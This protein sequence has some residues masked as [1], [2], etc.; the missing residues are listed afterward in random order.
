MHN[1]VSVKIRVDGSSQIGLGHLIRCIALGQM[2]RDTFSIYFYSKEIP[3]SIISQVRQEGFTFKKL[4]SED[5]FLSQ[6]GADEIV[7][8]D[9]YFF[10]TDYQRRIKSLGCKLVCIDDIHDKKFVSDIII[11]P[12]EGILDGVYNISQQITKL[13]CGFRYALIRDAVLASSG[14]KKTQPSNKSLFICLGGADPNNVTMDI[15][16]RILNHQPSQFIINIVVGSAY[17]YYNNLEKYIT[18]CHNSDVSLHSNISV[19]SMVDLMQK[20]SYAICS[21]STIAIEYLSVCRGNLFLKKTADNQQ[22]FYS[23]V[24]KSNLAHTLDDFFSQNCTESN[25]SLQ[26]MLFDGQQGLRI[27]NIF[28][29]LK[30]DCN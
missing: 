2:L 30:N 28:K 15:L 24:L 25:Y 6:L 3:D 27:N 20:S 26:D 23:F 5:D 7:V 14:D 17:K 19:G 12:S 8:L 21:P 9:N 11:N 10:D 29:D 18:E 16:T 4:S 13:F 1:K 22:D